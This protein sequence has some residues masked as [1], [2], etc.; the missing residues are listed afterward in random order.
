M[1]LDIRIPIGAMFLV[2]GLLLAVYG[3]ITAGDV[4]TYQKSLLINVNLWWSAAM[5]I[6]GIAML[7]FGWRGG[8]AGVHLAEDSAEGR[9]VEESEHQAGLERD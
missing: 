4:Q 3:L 5:L 7:Y 2:I 6:F 1:S 9:A 8:D